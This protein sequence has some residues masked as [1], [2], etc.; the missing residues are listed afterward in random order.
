MTTTLSDL[1]VA[2][3]QN[4][5]IKVELPLGSRLHVWSPWNPPSS[6]PPAP[7]HDHPFGFVSLCLGGEIVERR[8]VATASP[9]GGWL[10]VEAACAT[11]F[12]PQ[13]ATTPTSRR[14]DIVE[15]G[16]H[17]VRRG[18]RYACPAWSIHE[19]DA[20]LAATLFT[21]L[22]QQPGHS[23]LFARVGDDLAAQFVPAP[24]AQ[25]RVVVARALSAMHIRLDD[26]LDAEAMQRNML[27]TLADEHYAAQTK[28]AHPGYHMIHLPR[29]RHG[30]AGKVLEESLELIDAE[31]QG[32]KIMSLC[33]AADVVSA[34][35]GYVSE[36]HPGVA[37]DDI[38]AMSAVT[39]RAFA[40]GR[41][42]AE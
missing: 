28:D 4:G 5:F 35:R 29:H 13:P 2:Q 18:E 12:G 21:K 17:L 31:R 22:E 7:L 6:A 32:V 19:T 38:L 41:R 1:R 14:F 10:E 42:K 16:A 36:R 9:S 37:L 39:D 24:E 15:T 26:V 34:L 25:L 27:P 8:Y 23:R 3:H 33:E 30:E 20:V 40:V 11:S